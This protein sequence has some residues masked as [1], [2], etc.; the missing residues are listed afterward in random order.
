MSSA[1]E[2]AMDMGY[3]LDAAVDDRNKAWDMAEKLALALQV[4][5]DTFGFPDDLAN[6]EKALAEWKK[7]SGQR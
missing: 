2:D 1:R 6:A 7:F 4:Y 3:A 5:Y